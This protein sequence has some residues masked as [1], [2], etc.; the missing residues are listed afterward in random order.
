[1]FDE[2]GF[3][4]KYRVRN[5]IANSR[6]V[7]KNRM[8]MV[9]EIPYKE[10]FNRREENTFHIDVEMTIFDFEATRFD[11]D[12]VTNS[13]DKVIVKAII[14]RIEEI[15]Q[16]SNTIHFYK[17]NLSERVLVNISLGGIPCNYNLNGY[18]SDMFGFTLEF[19][20]DAFNGGYKEEEYRNTVENILENTDIHEEG[21][22][23]IRDFVFRMYRIV[24]NN[25][26]IGHMWV[27]LGGDVVKILSI[28]DH[29]KSD[30][31][32]IYQGTGSKPLR[33]IAPDDITDELL[34]EYGLAKS[35]LDLEQ[36]PNGKLFTQLNKTLT[37]YKEKVKAL[38]KEIEQ[39]AIK[40]KDALNKLA[41]I[42]ADNAFESKEKDR[43]I[44]R[45]KE[46]IKETKDREGMVKA[47][48]AL[49]H[50]RELEKVKQ[51]TGKNNIG[52]FLK[53]LKDIIPAITGMMKF[54][55]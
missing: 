8:G 48:T 31:I 5:H 50:K 47:D 7:I 14:K 54:L 33:I 27:K 22:P 53:T 17:D 19:K 34:T 21:K 18:Q 11:L 46:S 25:H 28:R 55:A 6:V 35:K 49:E 13:L 29:S 41:N 51:D 3:T 24:D 38:E 32:Y 9:S 37:E 39:M 16:T 30:G 52:D 23:L 20:N 26:A 10:S 4:V 42:I 45:L 43:I 15:K 1:M 36:G 2:S 40:H 44:N 12:S